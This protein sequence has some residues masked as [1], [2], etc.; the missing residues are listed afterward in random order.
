MWA[1]LTISIPVS[2]LSPTSSTL[3]YGG[4]STRFPKGLQVRQLIEYRV[5]HYYRSTISSVAP[6]RVFL[7]L[8]VGG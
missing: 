8:P 1:V 6:S 3:L 5:H 7:E 4:I 2:H